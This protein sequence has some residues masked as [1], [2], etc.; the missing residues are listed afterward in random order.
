MIE[1]CDAQFFRG[2][3]TRS[4]GA[5]VFTQPRPERDITNR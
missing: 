4:E 5:G 2:S 3:S 1:L